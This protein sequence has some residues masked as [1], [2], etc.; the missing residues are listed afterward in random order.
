M[1]WHAWETAEGVP[2]VKRPGGRELP[3]HPPW[4]QGAGRVDDFHIP[5]PR[6]RPIRMH[7]RACAESLHASFL[8]NMIISQRGMPSPAA[9]TFGDA[10]MAGVPMSTASIGRNVV[11]MV[12]PLTSACF[13]AD[14]GEPSAPKAV[15]LSH[16]AR[17]QCIH[18]TGVLAM[19]EDREVLPNPFSLGP[20]RQPRTFAAE[21]LEASRSNI[22]RPRDQAS[23]TVCLPC[24]RRA[25][26][27]DAP[28]PPLQTLAGL[29]RLPVQS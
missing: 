20:G 25:L 16:S 3:S 2:Q 9:W 8:L 1:R 18:R 28:H 12:L 10:S 15:R 23:M 7:V 5:A 6:V 13:I 27:C 24:R 17:M 4:Q 22:G 19:K 14:S 29:P 26:V 21:L 11:K